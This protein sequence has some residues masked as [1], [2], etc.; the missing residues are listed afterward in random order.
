MSIGSQKIIVIK[1]C[2]ECPFSKIELSDVYCTGIGKDRKFY[3]ALVPQALKEGIPSDCPLPDQT[4]TK[5]I[6]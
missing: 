4:V 5:D 2:V 6:S 1:N 3:I